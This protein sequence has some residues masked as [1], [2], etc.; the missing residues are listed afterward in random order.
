MRADPECGSQNQS[1]PSRFKK[2][3]PRSSTRFDYFRKTSSRIDGR[4][5]LIK[6]Y[7]ARSRS[8]FPRSSAWSKGRGRISYMLGI[9]AYT[10]CYY[11]PQNFSH[12]KCNMG[13]KKCIIWRS[14]QIFGAHNNTF[15]KV[16]CITYKKST[17]DR[18]LPPPPAY[19]HTA[20]AE[21]YIYLRLR[22]RIQ[23]KTLCVCWKGDFSSRKPPFRHHTFFNNSGSD[24]KCRKV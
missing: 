17:A 7:S 21:T 5:F 18:W 12:K 3:S 14:F 1:C 19:S 13:I 11:V 10:K 20:A 9:K 8:S 22:Y 15:C 6:K 24:L 23:S 4:G 2:T 16:W